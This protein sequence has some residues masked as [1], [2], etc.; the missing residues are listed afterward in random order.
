MQAVDILKTYGLYD[1]ASRSEILDILIGSK[2]ALSVTE[3][4]EK[5]DQSRDRVT[6]YRNLKLF[7]DKG[8]LHQIQVDGQIV[9]YV[10]PENIIEPEAHYNEH[11]HF[12]CM[13][14]KEVKCLTDRTLEDISLPEG[15]KM[16]GAN[17][18]IFGICNTC[19]K[20]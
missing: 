18:V 6:L 5:M 17:F 15:Y 9:K 7:T 12:K 19:N 20:N 4:R 3:I 10:L 13:Q 2:L 16:L 1:T 14:C 8:I 11:L